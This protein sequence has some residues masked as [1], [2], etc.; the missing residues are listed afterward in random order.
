M[1]IKEHLKELTNFTFGSTSAII[2]NISLV[3]GLG[4]S[5]IS[6]SAIIGSLLVI[7]VADNISDSLGIHI[8]KESESCEI[9]KSFI[10][11]LGNFFARLVISLSF[12]GIV[13][14]FPIRV[15]A[16]LTIIWGISLLSIIS[17]LIAKRNKE[18]P[19]S[20]IFKHIAI[21]VLVIA[22]SRYAGYIISRYY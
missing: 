14:L 5:S 7:A 13:L 17:Y 11:T 10:L 9:K 22:A 2:T 21:A 20:E 19:L 4:Y 15:A 3:V 16:A 18:N 8:Y 6:K 1:N 12:I